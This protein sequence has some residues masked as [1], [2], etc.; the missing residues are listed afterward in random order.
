[1]QTSW[2]GFSSCHGLMTPLRVAI[3]AMF[4]FLLGSAQ[5]FALPGPR[6]NALNGTATWFFGSLVD[7]FQDCRGISWTHEILEII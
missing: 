2:K 3:T 6:F 5:I 1:M 4:M 7:G